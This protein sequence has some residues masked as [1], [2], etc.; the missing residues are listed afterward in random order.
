MGKFSLNSDF[1]LQTDEEEY[2]ALMDALRESPADSA[3]GLGICLAALEL[4]RGEYMGRGAESWL[5]PY[6]E[7]YRREFAF[8]ARS[9]LERMERA[10]DWRGMSLLCSRAEEVAPEDGELHRAIIRALVEN[11]LEPEL[12][13][14]VARLSRR[15]VKWLEGYEYEKQP[16]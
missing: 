1:E 8:L 4:Q 7:Y 15:G 11:R 9:A 6:R 5:E 12:V 10:Q 14:H 13:R 16:D 3:E 2:R